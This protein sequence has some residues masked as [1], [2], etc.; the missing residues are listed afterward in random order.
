MTRRHYRGSIKTRLTFIILFVTSVTVIIGY[1]SFIYWNLSS[2]H[3]RAINLSKTVGD[4]LSQDIAK[5]ILLKDIAIAADITSGLKSFD[6]LNSMVL[7]KLDGEPIFQYSK[8]DKS[9]EVKELQTD[10]KN[11]NNFN[12]SIFKLFIHADYQ[13]THLGYIELN[14]KVDTIWDMIKRDIFILFVFSI[15]LLVFSFLLANFF[16]KKFTQPILKLVNFLNKID[17]IDS[18]KH[19]ITTREDNEFGKLYDEVNYMLKRIENSQEAE[20]IAA[21]A[22]ETKS[23]MVITNKDRIILQVNRAFCKITGYA[24]EEVIGKTPSIL[25]SNVQNKSFYK[26]MRKTLEKYK[27]W[28]GELYN[29][30]KDGTIYPEYLTI[31]TVLDDSGKVIYYVGSFIDLT[32]QKETEAKVE[33]LEQYDSLTGLANKKLL[34]NNIQKY[35]DEEKQKDWGTILCLDLKDFKLI[36]EAYG[37]SAGDSILQTI[38]KKLKESFTEANLIARIGADEFIIWFSNIAQTKDK[39]S[40]EAKSLAEFLITKISEPIYYE[41]KAINPLPFI[42]IALYNN[43]ALDA[44]ELFKEADTALHLAKKNE[45]HFSFFDEQAKNLAQTHLD[46]Y[47]QLSKAIKRNQFELYYQLQYNHK[48]E[49]FGAE[50]LIRW[51]HPTQGILSPDKFISIAEKTGLIIPITTWVIKNACMQLNIWQKEPK[52]SSWIIAINISAKEFSQDDFVDIVKKYIHM[53]EIKANRLKLELTESILVKDIDLVISKMTKLREIG[54][55]ISLD[56]FGTGYSSLQYLRNLPLNQVKI[57]RVFVNNILNNKNDVAIVKS[58]LLL[59]ESLNLEVVAEG[60][61]TKEHYKFLIELGCKLFQGFYLAK[62][63]KIEDIDALIN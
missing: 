52:S 54:V 6:N 62:P 24:K 19:K 60:V 31:Q 2:Q 16:A 20:K 33:Y 27:Y 57:D 28:S 23:G 9:F 41:N 11:E 39:A 35:L 45:Q 18:L 3:E 34:I 43:K 8:D 37:H 42:G 5:L 59:A 15:A 46:T 48:N 51:I 29:K 58:I 53:Y 56:D 44:N 26:K 49:I 40:I 63:S 4:V 7:Y 61:E 21:A 36:N 12:K 13:D 25:K 22:F 47:S 10:F 14:F 1:S 17:Y 38:T 30:H 32:L 55:Q 50:A